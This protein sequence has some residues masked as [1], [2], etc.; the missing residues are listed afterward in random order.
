MALVSLFIASPV[1]AQTSQTT[2]L[3]S[4]IATLTVQL[5]QLQALLMALQATKQ[6]AT[7]MVTDDMRSI[8]RSYLIIRQ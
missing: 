4:R 6:P 8:L 5:H 3:Q 2:L 1:Y 7:P